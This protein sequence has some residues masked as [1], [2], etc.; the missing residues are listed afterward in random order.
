MSGVQW[1]DTC[2]AHSRAHAR[3]YGCADTRSYARAY[4]YA[5]TRSYA[6]TYGCAHFSCADT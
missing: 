1:R 4:G 5:D 2:T 6:G 3:A